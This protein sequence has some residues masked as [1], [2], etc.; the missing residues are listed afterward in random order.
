[1]A[2]PVEWKNEFQ[3][4]TGTADV[5]GISDPQII[6]LA[7]G[8]YLVAWVEAG[9]TGVGTSAGNDVVGK[10]FDIEGNL[11][12][13]SFRINTNFNADD[14][15]DFDIAATNDGGFMI[16]YIDDSI[17]AVNATAV[18]WERHDEDGN[19]TN[20]AT[21]ASENVADDF[22]ANPK[23]VVNNN[24]NTSYVT[25]TDDVGTETEVRG[26]RLSDTGT[27]LTAEFDAAQN[28]TGNFSRDAE[29]AINSNGELVTVYE[30]DDA[31]TTSIELYITNTAGVQQHNV[32]VSSGP[33]DDAHVATL[34]NGNIVVTWSE[35]ST[36][37]YRVY[38]SNAGTVLGETQVFSTTNLL[39]EP[40]VEALPDG[41]FV[42]TWDNDT[43]NSLQA[44]R[45][46]ADGSNE[47]TDTV[48]T[49]EAT[50]GTE[51]NP[52]VGV[53]ADGRILFAWEE[54]DNVFSNIW[55]TRGDNINANDYDGLPLN[56]IESSTTTTNIIDTTLTGDSDNDTILGQGGDDLISGNSGNDSIEGGAGNDTLNGDNGNDTLN[57][58][59]GDDL[60]VG[61]SG[62]DT[63]NGGSG[64]DT[65]DYSGNTADG[66]VNIGAGTA[67]FG[68]ISETFTS[69]EAVITGS[70][71]DSVIGGGAAYDISTGAGNDTID[72]GLFVDTINAGSGN[73]SIV[74]SAGNAADVVNGGSGTDTLDFS[75]SSLAGDIIFTSATGGTYIGGNSFTS[76]EEI[77]AGT[78]SST[79]DLFL[80][81]QTVDAGDGDDVFIH[82]NGEFIDNLDGGAGTDTLDLSDEI[83]FAVDIDQGAGTW[84]GLG[85]TR[86]IGGIEEIIGT[87]GNDTID[88]GNIARVIDG[89][90][91]ND[92]LD[93]GGTAGF[94]DVTVR[95]GLG[96]DT[97]VANNSANET[98]DGGAGTD[99]L[100][101][102]NFNGAYN[103][104][105]T[106]GVTNFAGESFV[107]FEDIIMGDGNDSI[108]GTSGA[109]NITTR[110]GNDLVSALFGADTVSTGNGNDTIF[111]GG[112]NDS[113]LGQGG[114]D[115]IRGDA[116]ND[117]IRGGAG[118]DTLNGSEGNDRLFGEGSADNI[119]G[120]AGN[121]NISG[122]SGNDSITG[123]DGT[124]FI[125]GQGNNDVI[126][127]GNDNDTILGQAG[128][129]NIGGD[130]GNDV[131]LGGGAADTVDGGA[132]NDTVDGGT[133][134]DLVTGGSGDDS[135]L[136][137]GGDDTMGGGSGQDI[138]R[139]GTGD[140]EMGGGL[141]SDLM[142]GDGGSDTLDGGA[143]G[144]TVD[145]GTGA[146][147]LLVAAGE[148]GDV[149]FG[150]TGAD[151]FDFESGFVAAKIEDFGST[152]LVDLQ[153][154]STVSSFGD[155]SITYGGGGTSANVDLGGGDEI[156]FN[157]L[158]A[159]LNAG[160]F[161][162]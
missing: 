3:V 155:L 126:S 24:D 138:M 22:L 101:L 124:D 42:I 143:G 27:V 78:A 45:F 4:N 7:G 6:G 89:Q 130:A 12:R 34:T 106:T 80:G 97:I 84:T 44:R 36:V 111:G 5:S 43:L 19:L 113:L 118:S 139:G 137:G 72:G 20:T 69:I 160:D 95:G 47:P 66:S 108:V 30:E 63:F 32:S 162:F 122:G 14:E 35:E 157:N 61:G 1:M 144:D 40:D 115:S 146:D 38:N 87:Q 141:G 86:T 110:N 116:G 51:I 15:D 13:D 2:T 161:V 151:V 64:T 120:D 28:T 119:N 103:V 73:D 93:I 81:T 129:D 50:G 140:D 104:N 70:G 49:I 147:L 158:T 67:T 88:G 150:G 83:T 121:D 37:Y 65:L 92:F 53:S 109:N 99:L 21:I 85:G 9:I 125:Q 68:A 39:N 46:N 131:I 25:F 117:T 148:G 31:G 77:K 112:D 60:F 58:G 71:D 94:D 59:A 135:L 33:G 127:G 74:I 132:G 145:G 90:G 98:L 134:R 159:L 153:D 56:F 142:F 18:R 105:M 107:N 62:T 23:I 82:G 55:D 17:S 123:G 100:D 96:D 52:N 149:L 10:I 54:N 128:L 133:E 91:G 152:D 57:G 29:I 11:V 48:F 154:V 136:G 16:V 156:I 114:D 75:A 102:R 8:N 79:I 76:I 26:V 41:G